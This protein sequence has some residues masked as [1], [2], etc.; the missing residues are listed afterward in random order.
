[1]I[2]FCKFVFVEICILMRILVLDNYDSFVYNI[3]GLLRQI[4]RDGF[5][6]GLIW[7]V[8]LNDAVS[9]EEAG[10][11][12]AIILSPGPG[13]PCEAGKMPEIISQYAD[14]IPMLGICLGFQAIAEHFGASL[15]RLSHPRHGH[16]SRL[17]RID[18]NDPV[19]GILADKDTAVGRYHSWVADISSLPQ[20]IVPTSYDEDGNLMSFRHRKYKLFGTQFHPESIITA[21]GKELL[22]AFLSLV[23][24]AETA[25]NI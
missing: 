7:D 14:S 10:S 12:D 21:C 9:I 19:I 3:I 15:T 13:I 16:M 2:Y 22:V 18:S 17:C 4:N 5:L 23:K 25:D 8:R 11:Y 24:A 1:M 6:P 20:D